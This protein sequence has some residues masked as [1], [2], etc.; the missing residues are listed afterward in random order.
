MRFWE[1]YQQ[2]ERYRDAGIISPERM[3]VLDLNARALGISSLQLMEGAGYGLAELIRTYNP[4]SVLILCGSGNNGG[5]GMVAARHLAGETDVHVCYHQGNHPSQ[6][7]ITQ[8]RA[9]ESC[10]VGVHDIRCPGDVDKCSHLFH[11]SD[12]IVDALLGT[13]V[14]GDLREPYASM[15]DAANNSGKTIISADIPTPGIHPTKVCAFHQAKTEGAHTVNIGIPIVAEIC[16]GPGDLLLLPERK[17][18][19]HKGSGG[20]VL[21]IGGGPYQGAPYLAGMAALRAGADI[22][23]VASP[24]SLHFPD[25]IHE[26]LHGECITDEHIELLTDRCQEAD[27][28]ICG[29]GLG[30]NSHQVIKAIAPFCRKAVFDADALRLPLPRGS[31]TIYTPHAGEFKRISGKGLSEQTLI[32]ADE[33]KAANIP[34]TILLKGVVDIISEGERT[35][36]NRTGTPAMTTG[37]TGDV[38][39]GVCG[40]LLVHLPAFDAAC[41]GAYVTGRAGEEAEK[42]TG[43]GLTAQDLLY[44]IPQILYSKNQVLYD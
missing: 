40:A 43:Y 27:V 19:A 39:A 17:S 33:I 4:A 41:I 7:F 15:V 12:L 3:R 29:M 9:I 23:R 30:S 22:V 44:Y 8:L 24:N 2:I 21:I 31:E 38:L 37:G 13:G 42:T 18:S 20:N 32:R 16:T 1:S 26:P 11:Q 14:K 10:R 36:F 34:G 5:D 35:R 25:L 6:S 28:V